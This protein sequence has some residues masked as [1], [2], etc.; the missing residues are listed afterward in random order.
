[1]PILIDRRAF[2]RQTASASAVFA[3]TPH[4][5]ADNP[6]TRAILFSDT[7]IAADPADRFR[8]FS[9]HENLHKSVA[10]ASAGNFDLLLV[11]GDLARQKGEPDDYTKF[12]ALL[13][14]LTDKLPALLT[15]GNHDERKNARSALTKRTG[16]T[17][18][19]EQKLVS[20]LSLPQFN[21]ILL[22]SLMATNIAPGQVGRVQRNWLAE[23]LD[24]NKAKP[25]IVFVHHNPDAESDTALVDADRLLAL[26]KPRRWVKALVFGHTHEC[27][28]DKQDGLHLINLPAVGYNFT[29]GH[30][31][32]WVEASLTAR[33]ADLKL[34]AIAGETRDD[35]KVIRLVFR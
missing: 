13:E 35:G 7:H 2:L 28:F 33:G 10:Q 30:P 14:P 17:E 29:D 6:V 31:V 5:R 9:P 18:P 1:M 11:N 15:L 22:D 4:P 19:V 20:T 8:G 12:N 24:V 16:E 32:G 27:R 3:L 26:L 21:L 34:H 25:A 23:Y